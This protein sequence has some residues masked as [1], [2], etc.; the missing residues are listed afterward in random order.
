MEHLYERILEEWLGKD[1][2]RLIRAV[3]GAKAPQNNVLES[4]RHS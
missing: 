3:H 1:A 4:F 2:L